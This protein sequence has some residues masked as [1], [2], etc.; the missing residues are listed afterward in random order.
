MKTI[1]EFKSRQMRHR[2]VRAKIQ[3][4]ASRPRLSVFRSS[5]YIYASLINDVEGKTLVSANNRDDKLELTKTKFPKVE[6]AGLVGELLAKKA[7]AAKIDEVVFDRSGYRYIG[8]IA[9]VA[10]GARKGGLK[11]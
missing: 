8:R 5:K 10:T 11:F 2:R 7:K 3:G 4:T 9:A 6:V 1:K